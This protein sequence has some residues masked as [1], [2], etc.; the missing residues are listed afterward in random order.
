MSNDLLIDGRYFD[1]KHFFAMEPL[2]PERPFPS[3][4]GRQP[5]TAKA[6]GRNLVF[7]WPQVDWL[8]ADFYDL[9]FSS[10]WGVVRNAQ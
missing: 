2:T 5:S 4:E 7:S 3:L 9:S 8:V 6:R 1:T 10:V